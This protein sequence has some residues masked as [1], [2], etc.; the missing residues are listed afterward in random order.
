LEHI[1]DEKEFLTALLKALAAQWGEK[2]E[3]VLHDWSV[4]YEQTIVAIEGHV[5]GRKVGDCGSNLGLEVMRGTVQNGDI[6]NYVTQTKDG[7]ILRSSTVYIKNKE[8]KPIGALCINFDISDLMTA[9]KTIESLIMNRGET[10]EYFASDV[11]DLLDFLI[12]E[13]IKLVGK[14]VTYMT[15]EDKLKAL[16]YLDEKGAFLI[17]KSGNKICQF[18]DISKYTLYNYLDE[19]RIA[20]EKKTE[21]NDAIK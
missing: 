19:I 10:A 20:K 8:H 18:F 21:P 13:S 6:Y 12:Q 1:A 7:K 9:K 16:D 5:T 17:T 15:K 2:C 11:N 14:P 3:V 4:G